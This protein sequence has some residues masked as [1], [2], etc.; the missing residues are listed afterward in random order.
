MNCN[1]VNAGV[2]H[3]VI[4]NA[5][6]EHYLKITRSSVHINSK[7]PY[8]LYCPVD[9]PNSYGLAMKYATLPNGVTLV[10]SKNGG[11]VVFTYTQSGTGAT[12]SITIS[13][14]GTV[15]YVGILELMRQNN[16]KL[17]GATFSSSDAASFQ[18]QKGDD[19]TFGDIGY[20][21][22]EFSQTLKRI[23]SCVIPGTE[24]SSSVFMP[25]NRVKV[26][27]GF[28]M[29][30]QFEPNAVN[31]EL[32]AVLMQAKEDECTDSEQTEQL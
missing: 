9:L 10:V 7:L 23:K 24:S 6:E 17:T 5:S 1:R 14:L 31:L 12:D 21:S 20:K 30:Q 25:F 13:S 3:S 4:Y 2:Q 26:T 11:N 16:L 8:C 22:G 19:F 32:D 29:W 27:P 18:T 28:Y 15:S